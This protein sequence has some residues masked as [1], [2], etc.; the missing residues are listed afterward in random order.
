MKIDMPVPGQ[1][2]MLCSLW[3]LAFGDEGAFMDA[4]FT[5]GFSPDRCLCITEE[6]TVTA[7]LYWFPTQCQGQ[8]I[9]YIYGVATHPDHR[10]KGLC[11]MLMEKA[12]DHLRGLGYQSCILVPQKESLREMYRK[13]GYRDC[14]GI[15]EFFCTD[16]PYP[17]PM[18]SIDAAEYA[19]L[20]KSHLPEAGVIQEGVNLEFLSTYAKFYKGMDF[21]MAA[22]SDG[23]KLLALE[24]LGNRESA[25]GVLCALGLSQGSFRTPGNKTPFAM[26]HPLA[27]DA[28]LPSYFAFAFD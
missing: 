7:A 26:F 2:R 24:Y 25:P 14:T 8:S 3:Q 28:L 11:R 27:E 6:D 20:R 9:A 10:G 12:H 1:V 4:F 15:T 23:E 13:L 19:E 17:A 16:D 5:T 18:H 22:T 21:I